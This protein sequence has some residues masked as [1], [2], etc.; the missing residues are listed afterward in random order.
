MDDAMDGATVTMERAGGRRLRTATWRL[1]KASEHPPL[2]FFNGIGANIEAVAPLANAMPERAL[3]MFDMPGTGDSPDPVVPYNPSIMSWTARRLLSRL[4][5]ERVDV[6]GV[7]WGGSIAQHFALQHPGSTRKLVLAATGAGMLM[8]PGDPSALGAMADPTRQA[9]L[10]YMNELFAAMYGAPMGDRSRAE[11]RAAMGRLKPP[12]PVGY[13]YQL[14]AMFGWTSL[15][16]LPFIASDTLIMM[17]ADD[18]IVPPANGQI[19]NCAIPGSRLVVIEGGGH[20]FLLTH[21]RQSI[22]AIRDFL[23]GPRTSSEERHAA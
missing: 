6:M 20:L 23:G 19:L 22:A 15:P 1:D 8:V 4:A 16:A 18:R 10:A 2:L 7:S 5:V 13:A 11:K 21:S 17:G 9:D 14:M 3:I 12:S